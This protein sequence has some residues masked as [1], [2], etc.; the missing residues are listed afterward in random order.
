MWPCYLFRDV[1]TTTEDVISTN[2]V[3]SGYLLQQNGTAASMYLV[4]YIGDEPVYKNTSAP[5]T[6][7]KHFIINEFF[8]KLI[9]FL[10]RRARPD[11]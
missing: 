1:G 10:F 5:A 11:A 8:N 9:M 7:S 4:G 2:P 6:G 3:K